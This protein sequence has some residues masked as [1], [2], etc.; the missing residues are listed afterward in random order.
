MIAIAGLGGLAIAVGIVS[1]IAANWDAIPGRLK[2]G[3]DLALVAG[4]GYGVRHWEG[5]GPAWA[6]E[7]SILILAGLV[8][9]SIAL[10][11]QVYQLGG[12][13]HEAL[14]VWSLLTALLMSRAR[15]GFAALV[16]IVGLQVTWAS[17]AIWLA[18]THH[19][20][21]FSLSTVYWPPLLCLLVSQSDW[22]QQRRPALAHVLGSVGWV[23]LVFCAT[24]G[25][26]AFYEDTAREN[27]TGAYLGSVISLALSA[28]IITRLAKT[29]AGN[30]SKILVGVVLALSHLPLF[31]SPGDLDLL[32][33]LSFIGLW[34]LVAFAAHRAGHAFILNLATAVIGIRILVVYFE[35][36][37]SLLDTG[38]GLVVGG[39]LTLALVWLWDRKRRQFGRELEQEHSS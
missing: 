20:E 37:G 5:R 15:S 19:L 35:L 16:W 22:L 29:P 33:A 30:A 23:E 36:F 12:K 14:A 17:W 1:I 7:T 2:I 31:V 3:I 21:A 13:A 25:T 6:R 10:V 4:L 39:L 24:L 18:D 38:I 27:W 32:A 9:G 28:W 26:F 8:M 11:G 34:V